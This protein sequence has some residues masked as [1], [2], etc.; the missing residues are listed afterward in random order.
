MDT[1]STNLQPQEN[2]FWNN[3]LDCWY[4]VSLCHQVISSHGIDDLRWTG[5]CFIEGG[6]MNYLHHLNVSNG[7]KC[8]YIFRFPQNNATCK[9]LRYYHKKMW[10][11][12][13]RVR[14]KGALVARFMGPT[15][16]PSGADRTQVGPMLA[17]WTLLSGWTCMPMVS[18][19]IGHQTTL[20]LTNEMIQGGHLDV[21]FKA[22]QFRSCCAMVNF[23]QNALTL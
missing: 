12:C 3:P 9:G 16:G 10:V 1:P 19:I 18:L 7:K 20:M 15:W 14:W 22:M 23:V 5:S 13:C 21:P 4:P 17:P 2:S 8:K 11:C 6:L